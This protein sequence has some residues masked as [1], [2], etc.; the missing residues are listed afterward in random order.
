LKNTRSAAIPPN[1]THN[2][3][4]IRELTMTMKFGIINRY[5]DKNG[6]KVREYVSTGKEVK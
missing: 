4:D 3:F 6:N 2:F 5:F 1:A